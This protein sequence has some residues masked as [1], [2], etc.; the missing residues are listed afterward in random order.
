MIVCIKPRSI[1]IQNEQ[2][3]KCKMVCD[4]KCYFR[5][6]GT[7]AEFRAWYKQ[8]SGKSYIKRDR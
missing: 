3:K 8:V 2:F 1:C 4:E 5:E 7:M 6:L